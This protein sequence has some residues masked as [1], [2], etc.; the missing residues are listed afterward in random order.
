MLFSVLIPLYNAEKYIA[1]CIDSV[2]SQ[3][4]DDYEI[5][6]VDD[7]SSDGGS[8]IA[9]QYQEEHSQI[10]RVIHKENTG[11]LLTRRRL[12]QE[13]KGDYIL[14]IDSD[15]VIKPDLMK[16]LYCEIQRH[17][18]DM[19]I[20]NYEYYDDASQVFRSL[21]VPDGTVIEG[22]DKHPI[23]IK[24]LLGRD[25]NELWSKCIRREIIDVDAD[26]SDYQHV[27]EGD[28]LFCL[29][30]IFDST[31]KIE[32]L[33]RAYYRYRVIRT[34]ITHSA[35]F[36]S[37]YSF[38]T[39]FERIDYYIKKWNFSDDE[40]SQVKDRFATRIVDCAVACAKSA[41]SDVESFV[42][43]VTDVTNDEANHPIFSSEERKLSSK[44]YQRYYQFLMQKKYSKL[45]HIIITTTALSSLK[46]KL[47]RR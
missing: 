41:E 20:Y 13:A 1:E 22:E 18:P 2:L 46:H 42:A 19:L 33:D 17:H 40:R 29:L 14:W 36:L 26:Y 27:K 23:L 47:I 24:M 44:V 35:T 16:D 30:P 7:G 10:I 31:N 4:F 43:F 34:S 28:D 6:I 37:Y 32:Y 8:A 5:V 15:D 12:L 3:D 25:L 45:Y 9:D 38:R 21:F 39:I 11:V